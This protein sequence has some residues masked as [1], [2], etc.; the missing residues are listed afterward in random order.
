MLARLVL[1]C[2]L[3]LGAGNLALA[4]PNPPAAQAAISQLIGE[5]QDLRVRLK[6]GRLAE[7]KQQRR[8]AKDTVRLD[9]LENK[10]ASG[11]QEWRREQDAIEAARA[12]LTSSGC[13]AEGGAADPAQ[14]SRCKAGIATLDARSAKAATKEEA[15]K[16]QEISLEQQ[17]AAAHREQ[18]LMGDD[19]KKLTELQESIAAIEARLAAACPAVSTS[20]SAEAI[21]RE[22]PTPQL[23]LAT[24]KLPACATPGCTAFDRLA[25]PGSLGAR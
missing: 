24:A 21:K 5:L 12:Q 18:G 3:C 22:C 25:G 19:A 20:T 11:R 10:I 4:Q 6:T 9:K 7:D 13:K 1:I 23:N 8:A 15:L 14:A 16:K 17:R 2:V